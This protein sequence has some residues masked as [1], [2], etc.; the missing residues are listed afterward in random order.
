[1]SDKIIL[2]LM[3]CMVESMIENK[4]LIGTTNNILSPEEDKKNLLKV[5]GS[6]LVSYVGIVGKINFRYIEKDLK[7]SCNICKKEF[8]NDDICRSINSI[9]QNSCNC[10]FHSKC[11]CSYLNEN[12]TDICHICN[13]KV[14]D[15]LL[16]LEKFKI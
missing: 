12:N 14:E 15:K 9:Q 2:D 7:E 1:M 8:K 16:D 10:L 4:D 5:I 13:L 3:K 6:G 11:I